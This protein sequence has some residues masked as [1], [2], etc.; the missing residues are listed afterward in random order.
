V[1]VAQL[2]A[3]YLSRFN[4]A[5]PHQDPTYDSSIHTCD[6]LSYPTRLSPNPL[7]ESRL[8]RNVRFNPSQSKAIADAY[9][10]LVFDFT[11]ARSLWPDFKGLWLHFVL[12]DVLKSKEKYS[13][14]GQNKITLEYFA[15]GGGRVVEDLIASGTFAQVDIADQH[16]FLEI[17]IGGDATSGTRST[18]ASAAL[19]PEKLESLLAGSLLQGFYADVHPCEHF[20]LTPCAICGIGYYPQA[21]GMSAQLAPPRYCGAC[22]SLFN[23]QATMQLVYKNK[24][25]KADV[26]EKFVFG[27]QRFFEVFGFVPAAGLNRG[28]LIRET[29]DALRDEESLDDYVVALALLPTGFSAKYVYKTWAH[30]LNAADL[31]T[32]TNRGKGG[33]QSVATDGHLCLSLG[34]RAICEYLT[35]NHVRHKKEPVYPIDSELNPNGLMRADFL[36]KDVWIEFA[37]MLTDPLYKARMANKKALAAKN[38]LKW[39]QVDPEHLGDLTFLLEFFAPKTTST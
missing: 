14:F 9:S 34:E 37:G 8:A 28:R 25:D 18:V 38:N 26:Q 10:T 39:V 31:L 22:Y 35:R 2:Y 20:E 12:S 24:F 5:W 33:Y 16:Q 23:G 3:D 36:A 6:L 11:V 17:R 29:F 7:L 13:Y 4:E 1:E 19:E 21:E 30:F 27:L 15:P 32:L